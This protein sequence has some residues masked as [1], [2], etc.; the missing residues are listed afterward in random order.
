MD[1]Y[2]RGHYLN[3]KF[4]SHQYFT[5]CYWLAL[6]TK[7]S[8]GLLSQMQKC[9]LRTSKFSCTNSVVEVLWITQ[10]DLLELLRQMALKLG[11]T[12]LIIKPL[13]SLC[14]HSYF[15]VHLI[16]HNFFCLFICLF[17]PETFQ[18]VPIN[19]MFTACASHR[20]TEWMSWDETSGDPHPPL[21]RSSSPTT[22]S[23]QGHMYH[24]CVQLDF[25]YLQGWRLQDFSRQP[26]SLFDYSYSKKKK[27]WF[28]MFK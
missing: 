14:N 7:K 23:E 9:M 12:P 18:Q 11:W 16:F 10:K 5:G 15:P 20:I 25:E 13:H 19:N 6:T 2:S 4:Q 1:L 28:L 17:F 3:N 27:K 22:S 8:S 24:G 21:W 26:V